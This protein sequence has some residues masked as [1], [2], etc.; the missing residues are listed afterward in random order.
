MGPEG[1]AALLLTIQLAWKTK[2]ILKD[3]EIAIIIPIFKKENNHRG[4]CL[5]SIPAKI[6]T[7]ITEG[8][9]RLQIEDQLEETQ[10]AF[11]R[12]QSTQD[13]IFMLRQIGEKV[14]EFGREAHLCFIDIHKASDSV[15]WNKIS[16]ALRRKS[17]ENQQSV[18]KVCTRTA[19]IMQK[20][21]IVN[22]TSSKP[23]D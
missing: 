12:N 2:A 9:L 21:V 5:L 14:T 22:L 15:P 16:L 19:G 8:K 23:Q 18:L 4:I 17:E 13:H 1:F 6:Y 10:C 3:W 7:R 11:R 20:L